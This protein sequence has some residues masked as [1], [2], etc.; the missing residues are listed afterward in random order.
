MTTTSTAQRRGN[1][2]TVLVI[3]AIVGM[4]FSAYIV[5]SLL[6]GA[7]W[8]PTLLLKFG[9]QGPEREYGSSQFDDLILAPKNGHD[10]KYYLIQASDPFYLSPESHAVYLDRPTYRAQ[11]MLY[12]TISGGVGL[13][14]PTTTAWAMIVLNILAIGFGTVMTSLLARELGLSAWFGLAFALNP[15]VFVS[16]FVDS[17]E[18]FAMAFLM[19]TLYYM[20]KGRVGVAA[21]FMTLSVLSRETMVLAAAGM[22]VYLWRKE[23]KM[24]FGMLAPFLAVG[25][26]WS[27]VHLRL[28][29]YDPVVQDT[30]ALGF[31]F[32]GFVEAFGFWIG[33][34]GH[35][36]DLAAGV[37]L[38]SVAIA[39]SLR[40][41]RSWPLLGLATCGFSLLAVLMV[42]EVWAAYFDSMRVLAPL[43]TA[44]ILM[45]PTNQGPRASHP[46]RGAEA[47]TPSD[48]DRQLGSGAY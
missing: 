8:N 14:G 18:V 25:V 17:A 1:G 48:E 16:V 21:G 9:E 46:M 23:R 6:S 45:I 12:P 40:T 11:R 27:Y 7:D 10:G 37:L 5:G 28:G 43:I 24:A 15:G 19:G 33:N 32:R 3:V 29:A 22:A 42:K 39:I 26:W 13:F 31:P 36:G 4:A 44:Y 30:A 35:L 38:M 2:R 41:I 20:V 47:N 34:P